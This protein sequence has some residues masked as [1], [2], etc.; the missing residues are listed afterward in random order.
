[1]MCY[2]NRSL[3]QKALVLGMNSKETFRG[4]WK[5]GN[6]C[7]VVAKYLVNQSPVATWKTGDIINK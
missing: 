5:S 3:K 1:M 7:Y 6:P 4:C 2:H